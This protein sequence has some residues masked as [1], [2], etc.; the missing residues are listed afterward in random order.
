M[1]E[2]DTQEKIVLPPHSQVISDDSVVIDHGL[3]E[4]NVKL[5]R[6]KVRD[7]FLLAAVTGGGAGFATHYF[8]RL[9]IKYSIYRR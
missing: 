4:R 5:W 9:N 7:S 8:K 2:K 3:A 1:T 6:S